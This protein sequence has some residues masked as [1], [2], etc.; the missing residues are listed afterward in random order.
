MKTLTAGPARSRIS[1][2]IIAILVLAVAALAVPA[3]QADAGD[4]VFAI[5]SPGVQTSQV[6]C[7][8]GLAVEDFDSATPGATITYSSPTLGD[9]NAVA[10]APF[11]ISAADELGGAGGAGNYIATDIGEAYRLTLAQPAGYFGFWW[12]AGNGNN[13][14]TVNLADGSSQTF[15]TQAILNA[16]GLQGTPGAAGG[17]FGNPTPAF[18]GQNAGEVYAFV[19]IFATDPSA[20]ITSLVFGE[21]PGGVGR[22]ES[23][24]HSICSDILDPGTGEP[25]PQT[26]AIVIKKLTNPAGASGQ[27]AFT[28]NIGDS[29]PFTL[30]G[31]G[32]MQEFTD[33][34]IGEYTVTEGEIYNLTD[35]ACEDSVLTG[36]QSSTDLDSHTATIRLEMGETVTCIFTN[37]R[38][39]IAVRLA[40][41]SAVAQANSVV[42]SWETVDEINNVGFNV[43]RGDDAD[44]APTQISPTMIPSASPGSAQGSTYAFEDV[45]VVPGAAYYYW[46]QDTDTFGKVTTHGPLSV[47]VAGP[48][49]VGLNSFSATASSVPTLLALGGAGLAAIAAAFIA[50]RKRTA[51]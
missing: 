45:N 31:D 39:P 8:A 18:Q 23:D 49:A 43:L 11:I 2:R 24:N 42:L 20:K 17:H 22:F 33:V 30:L 40:D 21:K 47:T 32:D 36:Q 13:E 14:V 35:L 41:F 7:P 28:H 26:G 19:N 29:T 4:L 16:P 46:L 9:Y 15:S 51:S 12:S 25:I 44:I 34:P 3:A 37:T 5:E 1:S 38:D 48:T 50:R 27:F 6:S 10:D